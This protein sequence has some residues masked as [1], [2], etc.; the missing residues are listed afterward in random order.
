MLI[1]RYHKRYHKHPNI[2]V[3]VQTYP[4]AM[5]SKYNLYKKYHKQNLYLKD[6]FNNKYFLKDYGDY[7][8]IYHY[9]PLILRDNYY[10]IGVNSV[11]YD[12]FG[13]KM[14]IQ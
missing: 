8:L 13:G 14:K 6:R 4:E 3:I 2:E 1:D 11:R 10:N 5:I 7:M 12:L 9:K